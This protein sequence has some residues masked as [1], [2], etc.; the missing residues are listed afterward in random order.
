MELMVS[1]KVLLDTPVGR[2]GIYDTRHNVVKESFSMAVSFS[3]P[4]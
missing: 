1:F 4:T 3:L 2:G